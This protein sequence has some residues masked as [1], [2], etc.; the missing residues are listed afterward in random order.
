MGVYPGV[1][2][3]QLDELTAETAAYAA[4]QHP[5]FSKLAARVSISNLHK[6]TNAKFSENIK[7][8]AKCKHPKTGVDAPLIND[9][10]FKIVVDNAEFLD[11][12]IVDARDFDFDYFGYKTLEKSYLLR[13]NGKIIEVS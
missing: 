4:S 9:K 10:V 13:V 2:T 12:V 5:D 3:E 6:N 11:S 1:T 7:T 8:L